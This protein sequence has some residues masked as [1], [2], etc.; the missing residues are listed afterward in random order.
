M[1]LF[2]G[3]TSIY[4]LLMCGKQPFLFI[5][6]T[7]AIRC[8]CYVPSLQWIIYLFQW[9]PFILEV[10]L[11]GC[12]GAQQGVCLFLGWEHV[13]ILLIKAW[14]LFTWLIREIRRRWWEAAHRFVNLSLKG[15]VYTC[16]QFCQRGFSWNLHFELNWS[17]F[18]RSELS[19]LSP[20]L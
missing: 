3:I 4:A 14:F 13:Q 1:F 7:Y 12:G 20:G 16:L 19:D 6:T 17:L 11:W 18:H 5:L 8:Y 9:R 2:M 15:D 10:C